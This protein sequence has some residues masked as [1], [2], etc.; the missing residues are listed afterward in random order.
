MSIHV[1]CSH[2]WLVILLGC[3]TIVWWPTLKQKNHHFDE[4][5]ITGCTESCH[6]RN[7]RGSPWQKCHQNDDIFISVHTP[8]PPTGEKLKGPI[9]K[10]YLLKLGRKQN[11]QNWNGPCAQTMCWSSAKI[12]RG[13]GNNYGNWDI[14]T[15]WPFKRK[16]Y[17]HCLRLSICMYG[18][19][20]LNCTNTDSQ[21]HFKAIKLM[22]WHMADDCSLQNL[23]FL[24]FLVMSI[25]PQTLPCLHNNFSHIQSKLESPNV[26]L[27]CILGY[28]HAIT[29]D[30]FEPKSPNLP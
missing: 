19:W 26:H 4:I 29:C 10:V 6:F 2:A 3:L 13:C 22:C 12:W 24:Y 7:F 21:Y 16:E 9:T 1:S 20:S 15:P 28:L 8:Q 18:H 30:G 11:G 14:I 27:T 17:C 23:N 25:R 5:F